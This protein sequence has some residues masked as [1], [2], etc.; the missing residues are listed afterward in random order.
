MYK[1][2][3]IPTNTYLMYY[4]KGSEE[5]NKRF[6]IQYQSVYIKDEL[7]TKFQDYDIIKVNY[8]SDVYDIL[9]SL[10]STEFF[11]PDEDRD[12]YTNI[13]LYEVEETE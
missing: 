5:P 6:N 7:I 13:L 8:L 1:I 10:D 9:M 11:I 12:L 2:L 4:R 3:H